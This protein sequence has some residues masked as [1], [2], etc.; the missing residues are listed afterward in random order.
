MGG[1]CRHLGDI[2]NNMTATNAR[3]CAQLLQYK[4]YHH[5]QTNVRIHMIFIPTILCSTVCILHRVPLGCGITL[6]HLF[7]IAYSLYYI[8]LCLLPGLLASS[9]F[10]LLLWALDE[11]RIHFSFY[12]EAGLFVLG[13]VAQFIGHGFFEHRK[14]ALLDNLVQS[15]VAAPYFVLFELLFKLGF[16]AELKVDLESEI[17][18]SR[19]TVSND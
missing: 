4:R 18:A 9:L 5:Q 17:V 10:I 6:A 12:T 3:L 14:P 13:W 2:F 11:K 16:F 1:Y 15:L 19:K 8:S 7:S